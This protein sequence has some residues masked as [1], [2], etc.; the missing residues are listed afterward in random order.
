MVD[1]LASKKVG[2]RR[3]KRAILF[4][5]I[6]S[7]YSGLTQQKDAYFQNF[8]REILLQHTTLLCKFFFHD[9]PLNSFVRKLVLQHRIVCRLIAHQKKYGYKY[10]N[11][12]FSQL[13]KSSVLKQ[14]FSIFIMT[15]QE[16]TLLISPQLCVI[17]GYT[18]G[19]TSCNIFYLEYELIK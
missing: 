14:N 3:G 12:N 13:R 19:S 9:R 17:Y 16:Y 7:A 6:L 4:K 18:S 15:S 1:V 2:G 10:Q 11:Y 5:E 8:Q